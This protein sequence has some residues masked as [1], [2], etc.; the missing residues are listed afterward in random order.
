MARRERAARLIRASNG[1]RPGGRRDPWPN[2]GEAR[3][4]GVLADQ[5]LAFSGV[6]GRADQAVLLHLLDDR[7]GAV[8]ADRKA[9]LDVAGGDFSVAQHD[10]DRLVVEIA[11]FLQPA[12]HGVVTAA[13]L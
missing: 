11:G 6:V 8:V 9:P 2:K 12:G 7:G 13:V 1:V 10:G 5:D 4:G 3:S